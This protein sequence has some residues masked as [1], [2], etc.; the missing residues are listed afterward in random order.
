MKCNVCGAEI[1]EGTVTCP[2]C[3]CAPEGDGRKTTV[4]SS[5]EAGNADAGSADSTSFSEGYEG[6]S[7]PAVGLK[8]AN[9]LGYFALWMGALVNVAMSYEILSGDH[10]NNGF[11]TAEMIYDFY[12]K[13]L[14]YADIFYGACLPVAALLAVIGAMSILKFKASAVKLISG[15]YL[16]NTVVVTVYCA[17]ATGITGVNYFSLSQV[18]VIIFSVIMFCVNLGYFNKR[19]HIFVN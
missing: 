11:T 4:Y 9:F 10:Y 13:G 6:V 18:L 5:T 12:G 19:R 16:Y 2:Y 3:G 17:L 14:K 8:W 15:I 1:D 7:E